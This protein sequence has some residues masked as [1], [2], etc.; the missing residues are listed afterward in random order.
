MT[1]CQISQTPLCQYV[2]K[3]ADYAYN[4]CFYTLMMKHNEVSRRLEA[5]VS[6]LAQQSENTQYVIIGICIGV[7]VL[8]VLIIIPIFLWVIKDKSRVVAIFADI[9]PE[10]A[11]KIIVSS[12][13]LDIKNFRFKAK[14]I[15]EAGEDNEGFWNKLITQHR[16]G[17]GM[18][19]KNRPEKT[20]HITKTLEPAVAEKS[21]N[22]A[23]DPEDSEEANNKLEEEKVQK[24]KALNEE[25]A[26]RQMRRDRLSEVDYPLRRRFLVRILGLFAF[27]FV[28][29]SFSLYFNH[30]IHSN[31][32][33]AS[34]MLLALCKRSLY[35]HNVNF[36]YTETLIS[37]SSSML[38]SSPNSDGG[39][40]MM[41]FI[42]EIMQ[43]IT[44]CSDFQK[45][46]SRL[47]YKEYLDATELV[48]SAGNG[49]CNISD[50]YS[51]IDTTNATCD[52]MFYGPK[53][54]GMTY[55][56]SYYLKM[57]ILLGQQ[58]LT[59][60][61]SDPAINTTLA[62]MIFSYKRNGSVYL[63]PLS[64]ALGGLMTIFYN[65]ASQFF[66]MINILE[67]A[68]SATFAVVFGVAYVL[69]FS[70]FIITLNDEIW[71]T[72]EMM[73]MIP[74]NILDKNPAVREQVWKRRL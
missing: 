8:S 62:N 66:V 70:R 32:A 11:K 13:Q 59:M 56:L 24:Q 29:A 51:D 18:G 65:C 67:L 46:G 19:I 63:Y 69:I 47:I 12:R 23:A 10:E 42:N 64:Y 53:Y 30:Y 28:Y 61:F 6:G 55:G 21:D 33:S 2:L 14:W 25:Q 49:F 57:Y 1:Q 36:L 17:F 74:A 31:N 7:V 39:L 20:G 54:N 9:S 5:V 40:Y 26:N 45:S 34:K 35:V 58:Y 73:S 38:G 4:M 41:D 15:I 68:I 27:F 52:I 71:H 48:E 72:R 60:N 44:E 37:N 16:H 3:L 50:K 43:I 22:V